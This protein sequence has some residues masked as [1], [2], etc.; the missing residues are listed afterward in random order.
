MSFQQLQLDLES[1]TDKLE[2]AQNDVLRLQRE[3]RDLRVSGNSV[4]A[5]ALIPLHSLGAGLA[6]PA[7][8]ARQDLALAILPAAGGGS[9][10]W[11]AAT[12]HE[13]SMVPNHPYNALICQEVD[14]SGRGDRVPNWAGLVGKLSTDD[15]DVASLAVPPG[16]TVGTAGVKSATLYRKDYDT[17]MPVKLILDMLNIPKAVYTS[18][19]STVYRSPESATIADLV[20]ARRLGVAYATAFAYDRTAAR[21][22]L[23]GFLDMF[24]NTTIDLTAKTMI[25]WAVTG[26]LPAQFRGLTGVLRL[27]YTKWTK[28]IF[29]N[30]D[31]TVDVALAA[32]RM[33]AGALSKGV[34]T[35]TPPPLML[36][37][38]D[39][40]WPGAVDSN[41]IVQRKHDGMRAT[42]HLWGSGPG[43]RAW[44]FSKRG[45]AGA[46]PIRVRPYV[47]AAASQVAALAAA[48][49][50]TDCIFDGELV[51]I[52]ANGREA[53]YAANA[54]GGPGV[55]TNMVFYAFDVIKAPNRN[56]G[57]VRK[58]NA[59]ARYSLLSTL[60]GSMPLTGA[61]RWSR[62]LLPGSNITDLQTQAIGS[63]WEGLIARKKDGTYVNGRATNG[64]GLVFRWT[65][66]SVVC[67]E[68]R[69]IP[70]DDNGHKGI[71]VVLSSSVTSIMAVPRA[72]VNEHGGKRYVFF[73][74]LTMTSVYYKAHR[75]VFDNVPPSQIP[76]VRGALESRWGKISNGDTLNTNSFAFRFYVKKA[77]NADE[78]Q[79]VYGKSTEY[80]F[81][82]DYELA[83]MPTTKTA[84]RRAR[85]YAVGMNAGG[86]PLSLPKTGL[87]ITFPLVAN[88]KTS[89][90]LKDPY[91][92]GGTDERKASVFIDQSGRNSLPVP[93]CPATPLF[94][95]VANEL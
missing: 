5:E 2:S 25:A 6:A 45:L 20:E 22:D 75:S 64:N 85:L 9:P 8:P 70:I 89:D 39:T 46:W 26:V 76:R 7:A 66:R 95:Y 94:V 12:R 17:E 18:T 29:E 14:T 38:K 84:A 53:G 1:A 80:A 51:I 62:D 63:K 44:F 13:W 47:D 30:N 92:V 42:L 54:Y 11:M 77:S 88:T 86:S 41:Y 65:S 35:G 3:L 55:A 15:Y 34:V 37:A 68:V 91:A 79:V 21:K 61:L 71:R 52:D 67:L 31:G 58:G 24:G 4:R 36:V 40:A 59:E 90:L 78:E 50:L 32:A 28:K 27:N 83:V 33:Q 57:D 60:L 10:S 87:E 48:A 82:P 74:M 19:D 72:H 43:T 23:C 56:G 81:N 49:N 16:T 93:T 69:G 73:S